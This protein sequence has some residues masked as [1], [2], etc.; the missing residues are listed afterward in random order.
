MSQGV[1]KADAAPL[2]LPGSAWRITL[3]L[4]DRIRRQL[5]AAGHLIHWDGIID[6][7]PSHWQL[8][9]AD[10]IIDV[11]V[12]SEN[13]PGRLRIS[14]RGEAAG[15]FRRLLC[16]YKRLPILK[17][18]RT[19]NSRQFIEAFPNQ[20]LIR[21]FPKTEGLKLAVRWHIGQARYKIVDEKH[22]DDPETWA[23]CLNTAQQLQIKRFAM[24]SGGPV[25]IDGFGTEVN[26]LR[27]LMELFD[28]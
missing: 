5:T 7:D 26:R 8:R 2:P 1:D 11:S 17:I 18:S 28:S 4:Q 12:D 23:I 6:R 27:R 9:L 13:I 19:L 16:S 21:K 14:V 10:H 15:I 3:D 25:T 22:G 20:R 24:R